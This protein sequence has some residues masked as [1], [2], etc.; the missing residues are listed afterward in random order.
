[1]TGSIGFRKRRKPLR[2]AAY[3]G[4][5]SPNYLETVVNIHDVEADSPVLLPETVTP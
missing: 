3:V 5:P 2:K 1:V 4:P